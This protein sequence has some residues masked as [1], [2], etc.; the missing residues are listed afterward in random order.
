MPSH[1]DFSSYPVPPLLEQSDIGLAIG[2]A[3]DRVTE[4]RRARAAVIQI[5]FLISL[6]IAVFSSTG[7]LGGPRWQPNSS[8]VCNDTVSMAG[9]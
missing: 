9:R 1:S 3:P 5:D 2:A 4:L 7:G 6:Q 8:G